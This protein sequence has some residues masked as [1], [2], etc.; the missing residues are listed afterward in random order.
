MSQPPAWLPFI[1]YVLISLELPMDMFVSK[2]AA[3]CTMLF[4]TR[5]DPELLRSLCHKWAIRFSMDRAKILAHIRSRARRT[6]SLASCYCASTDSISDLSNTPKLCDPDACVEHFLRLVNTLVPMYFSWNWHRIQ[7]VIRINKEYVLYVQKELLP[8]CIETSVDAP[9]PSHGECEAI[10]QLRSSPTIPTVAMMDTFMSTNS[11]SS[12]VPIYEDSDGNN[13]R[14]KAKLSFATLGNLL[15]WMRSSPNGLVLIFHAKYS[16]KSCET[17][18]LFKEIISDKLLNPE[19]NVCIVHSVAEPELT[20]MYN[21]SWFPTIIY[22]PPL[23]EDNKHSS[24]N[25]TDSKKE[26]GGQLLSIEPSDKSSTLLAEF[27][28][29]GSLMNGNRRV[30]V[31]GTSTASVS[32]S[33]ETPLTFYSPTCSDPG[34]NSL[35]LTLQDS[36]QEEEE[37]TSI[38]ERGLHRVYP[39]NSEL[40]T[41]SLV[42]WVNSKGVNTPRSEKNDHASVNYIN[43]LREE[44]KFKK[45]REFISAVVMLRHLQYSSANNTASSREDAP[46]FIFLGGGMAAGKSTAATALSRSSWWEKHKANSVL[47]NADDFKVAT[48]PWSQGIKGMHESSAYA[49]EKLMVKAVNQGRSIVFDGT[50]MWRPFV[51]QVIEMVRHAHTTL[52]SQGMGYKNNGAIEEYFR[53]VGPRETPLPKPYE[54]R[55]LAI[56]VEPEIAVPRGILRMFST[57]RGVPIPIQLRSFRLFAENFSEYLTWVDS[58][59][60]YNNNVFANLEKGE[61]P[62]VLAEKSIDGQ[63]VV[64]NEDAY[65]QFLRQRFLN[66]DADNVMELYS[67]RK[68]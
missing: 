2:L 56:T 5:S 43:V 18:S 20:N 52:Y 1:E 36:S 30:Q 67:A 45:Y 28:S 50:M 3:C 46:V 37:L 61:L 19:P 54:I 40:T 24:N 68:P 13:I 6:R 31:N 51:K 44:A 21:I 15:E 65:A 35:S 14:R 22:V 59:T 33:A 23:T 26:G 38:I 64:H 8:L 9:E 53:P 32:V 7:D 49:A 57:G 27:K 10:L 4:L 39:A 25:N 16:K 11:M 48:T 42:E 58:A 41:K 55:L 66:D 47:V 17:L 12:V 29:E 63:L 62:P 60:L 34:E